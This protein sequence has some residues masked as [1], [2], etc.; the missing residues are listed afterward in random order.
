MKC[1]SNFI[2]KE[3][4]LTKYYQAFINNNRLIKEYY[5]IHKTVSEKLNNIDQKL[6]RYFL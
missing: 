2:G 5:L 1:F 4:E 3:N 6:Y